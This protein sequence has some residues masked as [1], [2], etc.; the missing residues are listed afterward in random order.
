MPLRALY[1][2]AC[3]M[4]HSFTLCRQRDTASSSASITVV[5][6]VLL[7]EDRLL[8]PHIRPHQAVF[9][10]VVGANQDNASIYGERPTR[11]CRV[12]VD[13]PSKFHFISPRSVYL[14]S[15]SVFVFSRSAVLCPRL[16]A[17]EQVEASS[18]S[19]SGRRTHVH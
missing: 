6:V 14:I 5:V 2:S 4:R 8:E 16:L 1:A 10:I 9:K 17:H 15:M 11:N 3:V 7:L 19:R 13:E 12:V 18:L